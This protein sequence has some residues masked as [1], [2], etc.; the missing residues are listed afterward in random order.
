MT[1][2]DEHIL[3]IMADPVSHITSLSDRDRQALRAAIE[4]IERLRCEASAAEMHANSLKSAEHHLAETR[5]EVE[6][7]AKDLAEEREAIHYVEDNLPWLELA[8]EFAEAREKLA[9]MRAGETKP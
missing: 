1:D 2:R 5:K 8:S 6:R 3:R 4:E 7:L 9:K